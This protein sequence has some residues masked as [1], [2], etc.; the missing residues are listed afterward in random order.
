M[1]LGIGATMMPI[2]T[3]ALKSLSNQDVA[4]G[5]TLTNIVQQI[6]GSVGAAVMS[7]ILTTALNRSAPIPGA[8]DP[9][10]GKPITEA[11]LAIAMQ[12]KPELAQVFPVDAS[13]I[14]NGLVFAAD[15][16][17]STFWVGFGL[18]VL[19]LVPVAFLPRRRKAAAVVEDDGD[20]EPMA[21]A[22]GMH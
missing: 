18:V 7:V 8:V 14:R 21:I 9:G 15:S 20:Q 16:F 5:S 19:T 17:G 6:G 22:V 10:S 11:G 13:V 1:G 4:R 2:M 12:Q 3:S